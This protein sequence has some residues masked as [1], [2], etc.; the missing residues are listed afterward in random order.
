[1][2]KKFNEYR[3]D[4]GLGSN[5]ALPMVNRK[6]VGLEDSTAHYELGKSEMQKRDRHQVRSCPFFYEKSLF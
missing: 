2:T 6:L 1:V 4:N 5:L 3:V